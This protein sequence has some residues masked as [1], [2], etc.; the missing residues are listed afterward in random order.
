MLLPYL[1]FLPPSI[2]TPVL[3]TPTLICSR[4]WTTLWHILRLFVNQRPH[5][6][7]PL[8]PSL[9]PL[10]G[11]SGV[12]EYILPSLRTAATASSTE[13]HH[14][15]RRF[16]HPTLVGTSSARN[17]NSMPRPWLFQQ[18]PSQLRRIGLL[19]LSSEVTQLHRAYLRMSNLDPP[20]LSITD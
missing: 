3:L 1:V 19:G 16:G 7:Y 8:L 5:S 17:S 2:S 15:H 12:R 13:I 14:L 20:T 9:Q 18:K 4:I 6:T 10:H 11:R